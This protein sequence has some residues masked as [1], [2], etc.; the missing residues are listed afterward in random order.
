MQAQGSRRKLWGGGQRDAIAGK[1]SEKR[2][3]VDGHQFGGVTAGLH[4]EYQICGRRTDDVFTH[5]RRS[6]LY[7]RIAHLGLSSCGRTM[8]LW[9]LLRLIPVCLVLVVRG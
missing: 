6:S 5:L 8:G 2:A 4:F 1:W 7:R 9:T 3:L